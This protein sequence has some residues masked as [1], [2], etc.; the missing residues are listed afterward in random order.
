MKYN[1]LHSIVIHRFSSDNDLI[2]FLPQAKSVSFLAKLGDDR[3]LSTMTQRIFRA[4]MTHAV[5]DKRWP[6][7]EKAFWHFDPEKMLLLSDEHFE[8]LMLNDKLIRHLAKMRSI[9]KNAQFV[10]DIRQEYNSF[11]EFIAHWPSNDIVSLW[12]ILAKRGQ[13]L[14]GRSG[15]A[16]LRMVGKDSFILTPD[17][18]Q[19]LIV[20]GAIDKTPTSQADLKQVQHVFN[21]LQD[22]SGLQLCQL[23]GMLALCV[24]QH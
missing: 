8:K 11:G 6:A 1:H 23:S 16:F 5:V 17:V 24:N 3:Y 13:R 18:I 20:H 14:G 7:F 4:G 21:Q 22:E 19:A 12:Q 10:L 9:P 15:A 2:A